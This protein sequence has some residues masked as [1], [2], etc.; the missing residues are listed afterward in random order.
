VNQASHFIFLKLIL[1]LSSQR[2]LGFPPALTLEYAS[3]KLWHRGVTSLTGR[4][5]WQNTCT[6]INIRKSLIELKTYSTRSHR[7]VRP[8]TAPVAKT[9]TTKHIH[10]SA[11]WPASHMCQR[12]C[13]KGKARLNK[14]YTPPLQTILSFKRFCHN[15]S[16]VL[17]LIQILTAYCVDPLSVCTSEK[18]ILL[19]RL[20]SS[21]EVNLTL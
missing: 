5:E 18:M 10:Q 21:F 1:I 15:N 14:P 20:C 17:D 3:L 16:L 8:N 19:C 12:S 2:R 13:L 11:D 4:L 9:V 6:E 7:I